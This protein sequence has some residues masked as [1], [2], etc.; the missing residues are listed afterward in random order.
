MTFSSFP[1]LFHHLHSD[2]EW[3]ILNGIPESIT[4]KT[5]DVSKFED[6]QSVYCIVCVSINEEKTATAKVISVHLNE[7]NAYQLLNRLKT[8]A[9]PS[10]ELEIQTLPLE[11]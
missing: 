5:I 8:I 11:K 7:M 6:E 3:T 1:P 2:G 4:E 10:Y 9:D